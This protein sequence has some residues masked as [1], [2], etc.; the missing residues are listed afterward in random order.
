[1]K[2]FHAVFLDL[3]F[4]KYIY[5]YFCMCIYI[6]THILYVCGVCMCASVHIFRTVL[7]LESDNSFVFSTL[8]Q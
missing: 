8:F 5:I 2:I 7:N 4:K 3:I 6:Y 1:M